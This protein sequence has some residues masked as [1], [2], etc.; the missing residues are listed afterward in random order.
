[1]YAPMISNL[2]RFDPV[3]RY[4][5]LDYKGKRQLTFF[6]THSFPMKPFS[7]TWKSYGFLFLQGRERVH[8]ERMK[9]IWVSE[10]LQLKIV[11]TNS[12]MI[13][14]FHQS[15]SI[16]ETIFFKSTVNNICQ[17]YTTQCYISCNFRS[18][19]YNYK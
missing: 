3:F 2:I 4:W 13:W 18:W 6:L 14:I 16:L 7:S 8:W 9:S 11:N 10:C 19:K 1:M 12:K 17:L 5:C 15:H